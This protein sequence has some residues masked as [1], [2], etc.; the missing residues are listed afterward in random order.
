MNE[1]VIF[2]AVKR[3]VLEVLPD[4]DPSQVV[5]GGTLTDLGANSVDRA[6][7]VTMTMEDLGLTIPIAEFQEVHDIASLVALLKR[8]S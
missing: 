2:E 1:D 8:H 4:L 6:D 7:V 3:N 5:M